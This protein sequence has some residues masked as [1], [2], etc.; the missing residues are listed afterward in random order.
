MSEISVFEQAN[1]GIVPV[2]IT[3]GEKLQG[4]C[5]VAPY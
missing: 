5:V 1:L 4:S 3:K 2:Y